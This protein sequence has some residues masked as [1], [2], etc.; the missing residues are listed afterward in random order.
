M[1]QEIKL[2][3]KYRQGG[4]GKYGSTGAGGAG[5]KRIKATLFRGERELAQE[6]TV[7][8]RAVQILGG[9]GKIRWQKL[10]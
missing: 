10:S 5:T 1:T 8:N 2:K 3:L 7:T 9:N 4:K 6:A